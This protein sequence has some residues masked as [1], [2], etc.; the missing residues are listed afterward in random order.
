MTI[1]EIMTTHVEKVE[2]DARIDDVAKR[3][4]ELDVGSVPVCEG[5]RLKGMV[6]DRDIVLRVVAARRDPAT[7]RASDIMSEPA[8]CCLESQT[9]EEAARLM[10]EHQIRRIPVVNGE[11]I[12]VGMVSLGDL[13][14][15]TGEQET[16]QS[17]SQPARPNR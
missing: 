14:V 13:A 6:T 9:V 3:M 10:Q 2:P 11:H 16:L 1:S 4:S 12:L 15:K 7:S 5:G 17:V 8:V